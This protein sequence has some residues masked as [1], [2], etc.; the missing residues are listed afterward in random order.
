MKLK[1]HKGRKCCLPV[2]LLAVALFAAIARA[3]STNILT[4]AVLDFDSSDAPVQGLGDQVATLLSANLSAQPQIIT[5]DRADLKKILSEQEL[6]LSGTVAADSAAKVG[7]LTGAKVL[8]TGRVFETGDQMILVSKT[9]GTETSRVYGEIVSGPAN[10]PITD[11]SAQLA[12]K[13]AADVAAKGDTLVAAVES[14]EDRIAKMKKE[15]GGQKLPSVS[16]K[17]SEQHFGEYVIDP[18]AET[19]LSVILQQCGFTIVD[20]ASTNRP[21]I[22]ITGEALTEYGMRK[23][24]LVSCRARIEIKAREAASGAVLDVD[25]QTS[26]A[27]DLAE[28]IAAKTALQNGMDDLAERVV[29]KLVSRP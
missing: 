28:H 9:I 8:V 20:E 5:V 7:Q 2:V 26:V 24:N 1:I 13:I 19:E 18:A 11:L 25:R 4:V 23:G 12:Q 22:E 16:V 14:R 3:D 15:L 10:A 21:D 27:V 29:P 17:I 6:G